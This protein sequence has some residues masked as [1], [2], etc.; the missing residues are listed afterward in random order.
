LY[1]ITSSSAQV[2]PKALPLVVMPRTVPKAVT[3]PKALRAKFSVAT[4]TIALESVIPTIV[5]A[6]VITPLAPTVPV[7]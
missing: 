7:W 2:S 5:G 1:Q 3:L 6:K 4:P